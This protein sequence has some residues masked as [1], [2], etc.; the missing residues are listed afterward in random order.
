MRCLRGLAD[1]VQKLTED[2]VIHPGQHDPVVVVQYMEYQR[3]QRECDHQGCS[4]VGQAPDRA[5]RRSLGVHQEV[6]GNECPRLP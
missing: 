2:S 6:K 1:D 3:H 5:T 4:D